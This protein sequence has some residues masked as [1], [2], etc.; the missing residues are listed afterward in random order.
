M[1]NFKATI[2]RD[3]T[4][5][6]RTKFTKCYNIRVRWT[7]PAV[8]TADSLYLREY[9]RKSAQFYLLNCRYIE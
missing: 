7:L 4:G 8:G 1:R 6:P 9:K 3:T 5:V 2:L